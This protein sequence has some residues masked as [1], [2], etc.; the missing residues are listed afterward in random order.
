VFYLSF[1]PGLIAVVGLVLASSEVQPQQTVIHVDGRMA[2]GLILAL[3]GALWSAVT[4]PGFLI[5]Q[6]RATRGEHPE[7]MDCFRQGLRRLLPYIG[8]SILAGALTIMALIA[9]IVPGLILIRGFYLAQY[10]IVD[11]EIGMV[12]ALKKSFNDSKPNAGWI[13]GTIGVTVVFGALGSILG[14]LP[15]AGYLLSLLTGY[16]YVF[17]PAIRYAEVTRNLKVAAITD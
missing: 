17:A 7:A 10:Y 4:H 16:V 1:L 2:I 15:V 8:M 5:L 6:I 13:W 12:D 3:T 9:L 14:K 11:E